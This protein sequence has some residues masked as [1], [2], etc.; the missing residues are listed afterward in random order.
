MLVFRQVRNPPWQ[1]Q[2]RGQG[3]SDGVL[4]CNVTRDSVPHNRRA[5]V[6]KTKAKR[7]SKGKG[8]GAESI[9]L[10]QTSASYALT[11]KVQIAISP[12]A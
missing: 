8:D 6:G 11:V 1:L 9:S 3:T 10:S 5:R 4:L 2:F 12:T 7:M